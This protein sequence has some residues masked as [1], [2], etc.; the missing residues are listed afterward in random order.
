[1]SAPCASL[2]KIRSFKNVTLG[3][4]IAATGHL[5]RHATPGD[6]MRDERAALVH[7]H[8]LTFFVLEPSLVETLDDCGRRS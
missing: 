4:R 6:E 3:Q 2:A 7:D 5:I 8:A 1:M